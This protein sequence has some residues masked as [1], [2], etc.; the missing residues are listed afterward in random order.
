MNS[1]LNLAELRT[2]WQAR[3]QAVE[4]AMVEVRKDIK[5]TNEP[6]LAA[7]QLLLDRLRDFG[8]EHFYFFFDG[9]RGEEDPAIHTPHRLELLSEAYL[10]PLLTHFEFPYRVD[11]YIFRTIFNQVTSDLLAIERSIGQWSTPAKSAALE[12]LTETWQ[13]VDALAQC[14]LAPFRPYVQDYAAV[15]A[16]AERT[17]YARIFPYAPMTMIGVPLTAASVAR[18]F[19]MIP[20]EVAHY[21]FWHG[22]KDDIFLYDHLDRA[23]TTNEVE[24]NPSVLAWTE[25]I[26]ADALSVLIAGPVMALSIQDIMLEAVGSGFDYDNGIHPIPRIRPYIHLHVLSKMSNMA[27]IHGQLMSRWQCLESGRPMQIDGV[28]SLRSPSPTPAFPYFWLLEK[29]YSPVTITEAIAQVE[30]VVDL[31]LALFPDNLKNGEQVWIKDQNIDQLYPA[32]ADF[33]VQC[34]QM[35]HD[36]ALLSA[37][38]NVPTWDAR[39]RWATQVKKYGYNKGAATAEPVS[40]D[41]WLEILA[42]EGWTTGGGTGNVPKRFERQRLLH[43]P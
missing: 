35:Q 42:F 41:V 4:A 10:K 23:F 2:I 16:T 5:E 3:W 43:Q 21:I 34:T 39:Y 11:V 28:V 17:A 36:G 19:L 20:H 6:R 1:D 29:T 30:R 7:A 14:G 38:L 12:P 13:K 25:E 9:L 37:F 31:I 33:L 18:D 22:Q 15:L 8:G 27:T 40:Y 32:F 24:L 26:F